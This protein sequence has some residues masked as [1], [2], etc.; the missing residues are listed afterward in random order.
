MNPPSVLTDQ[1]ISY[2]KAHMD[3]LT[4]ALLSNEGHSNRVAVGGF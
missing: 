1:K 2:A 4:Q 3:L